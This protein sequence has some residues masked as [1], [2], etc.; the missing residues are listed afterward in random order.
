MSPNV[1]T[2]RWWRDPSRIVRRFYMPM[3]LLPLP[4]AVLLITALFTVPQIG[5]TT[6]EV[7]IL[8]MVVF[9]SLWLA[10]IVLWEKRLM[11]RLRAADYKLCP[12]CG[13]LLTAREGKFNCPECGTACDINKIQAA[14]RSFRPRVTGGRP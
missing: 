5:L 4:V 3:F 14:W 9:L 8:G 2:Y 6:P 12:H 1:T 10:A 13:Y 11:R 7:M